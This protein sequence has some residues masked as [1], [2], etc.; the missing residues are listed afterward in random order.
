MAG[1]EPTISWLR[2]QYL[3]HSAIRPSPNR[4]IRPYFSGGLKDRFHCRFHFT[5]G[6]ITN[7]YEGL[8]ASG[9]WVASSIQSGVPSHLAQFN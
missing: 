1:L 2:V 5:E 3:N 8:Y 6:G 9:Q 4:A 7:Y